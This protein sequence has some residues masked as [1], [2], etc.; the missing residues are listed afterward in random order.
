[1]HELTAPAL[2]PLFWPLARTG[3]ESAWIT[4]VPFAHWLV[5]AHRPRSIVE[6]GTHSGVSFSAFCEAVQ[7]AGLDC[8]CLA[9]D[10][11]AGDEHAGL[12]DD[13]VFESLQAF[14][15][16]RYAG[17]AQLLRRSFDDALPTVPDGSIDLL[18]IDG[19]HT[20]EAVRHDLESWRPKLSPRAVVLLH[21]TNVRD[22][23]FGVWRLFREQ[24]EH[25]PGFE[26]LHG[27]G[28]GLLAIGPEPGPAIQTLTTLPP[29]EAATLRDRM[30][31]LGE[32]WHGPMALD[33]AGTDLLQA[34]ARTAAANAR[35]QEAEASA[36]AA[37]IAARGDADRAR[38]AHASELATGLATLRA[39]TGDLPEAYR[40]AG[41]H[42]A[43]LE[44]LL[45]Q[46]RHDRDQARTDLHILRSS[47]AWRLTGPARR[48]ARHLRALLSV[49]PRPEPDPAPEPPPP[50]PEPAPEPEPAPPPPTHRTDPI[51]IVICVHDAQDSL[52]AC[53]DALRRSTLPP[54]CIILVD[55][56]SGPETAAYLDQQAREQ[57]DLLHRHPAALGYTRAANAGLRLTTAP[58]VVLLNSDTIPTPGWL[59][60]LWTHAARNPRLGVVGPLSNTASWQSVPHVFNAAG[61]WADNPLPPGLTPD[62]MAHLV[63][64]NALGAIPLP[65]INGFCLM[66][67][68]A[69]L[70]GVGLFDEA[71]FGAGYG[72]ENDYAIRVRAG[73]WDLAVASDA[74]VVHAQSMSYA[75]R[76]AAL[77]KAADQLLLQKHDPVLHILPQAAACRDSLPL[78]AM[79]A[80]LAAGWETWPLLARARGA[81]EGRRVAFILPIAERGGGGNVVLQESRALARMGIDVTLLTLD[82]PNSFLGPIP[83]RYGM[84]VRSFPD[85]AA[86][87][88][89]LA[90]EPGRYDAVIATLYSTV[91]WLPAQPGF[92]PAYYIQDFEPLF[93]QPGTAEHQQ[94]LRSYTASDTLRLVTKTAW[95]QAEVQRHT[96]RTPALLGPSVDTAAFAPASTRSGSLRITAMVRPATPRR[97][98]ARTL[99]VLH[100]VATRLGDGVAIHIF[101]ATQAELAT[102]GLHPDWA[103]NE[104]K[105]DHPAL[106]ALLARTDIF[107]DGSDYQ[108]MGLTALEAMLSGCAVIAPQQGGTAE[109]IRSGENGLLLD[110][111]D[112]AACLDAILALAQDP[113]RLLALRLHAIAE[114]NRHAP[115]HA[116]LR[117]LDAL[118]DA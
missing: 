7:R 39:N 3:V 83:E 70:D 118:F 71:T 63:A 85:E 76:R 88:D 55:D 96:G 73:G 68:R 54:Y 6:L 22:R 5:A 18:H 51:D 12:Y 27:N 17:F 53:L 30:A 57:G 82:F 110:T 10:T 90:T 36:I 42:I 24:R 114:A 31:F 15:A 23:G 94:A 25:H 43:T 104:G 72:E 107:F 8:R 32:R 81:H 92:V 13:S 28:L 117:L 91:F 80:R 48:I 97:A 60:R 11:W 89:H 87:T 78:A 106:A 34:R 58:W 86:L 93:F 84:A 101:G 111:T 67:R 95:N 62:A 38:A 105:L 37:A 45:H 26:F 113:A 40:Q 102:A 50:P 77:S 47:T 20:Y 41:E 74:Y 98:A 66:I 115:E 109:F 56:G 16:A 44:T 99:A 116:A 69:V 61:D 108:A 29:P 33:V 79:R 103:T 14:H 59:D 35:A 19:L 1:M 112:E 65:F 52:R 75:G 4:H 49:P 9:V 2:A 46:A 64:E 21:D 100:Q